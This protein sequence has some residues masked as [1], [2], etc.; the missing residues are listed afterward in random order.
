M[1][2]HLTLQTR[3]ERGRP[4]RP[5]LN[6]ATTSGVA[7]N[8]RTRGGNTC[9]NNSFHFPTYFTSLQVIYD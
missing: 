8:I 1:S 4:V 3:G 2:E 7:S 6:V 5:G 9:I